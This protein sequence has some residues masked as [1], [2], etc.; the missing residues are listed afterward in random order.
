MLLSHTHRDKLNRVIKYDDIAVWSNGKYKQPMELVRV[1]NVTRQK[2]SF[3]VISTGKMTKSFPKN[4]IVI[5][6]QIT[7]NLEGNVGANLDIE[8]T[9]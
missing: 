1:V 8:E 5:T 6:Q 4:L 9:R 2:V 3:V 7:A